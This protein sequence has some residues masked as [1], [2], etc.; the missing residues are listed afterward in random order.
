M[1]HINSE[2]S[3]SNESQIN[4]GCIECIMAQWCNPLTLQVEQSGGQGSMP[5]AP[6]PLSVT[7][8]NRGL[9]SLLA[10]TLIHSITW[11]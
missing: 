8:R 4:L 1:Q 3:F 10:A 5:I 11:R 2:L 7:V 9:D 6:R